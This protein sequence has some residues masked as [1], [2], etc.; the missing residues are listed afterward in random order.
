MSKTKSKGAATDA[1]ILEALSMTIKGA[2][3]IIEID[4]ELLTDSKYQP[5]LDYREESIR[6]LADNIDENGLL[7]M[8]LVHRGVGECREIICG[9]RRVRACALL[10]WRVMPVRLITAD[11]TP[12]E[13]RAIQLS[14]NI[15]REDL[16]P[17]ETAKAYDG[18]LLATGSLRFVADAIGVKTATI[19][20]Q[21]K[22]LTL[23]PEFQAD[24]IAKK[25]TLGA[26]YALAELSVS[27]QGEVWS[28]IQKESENHWRSHVDPGPRITEAL[29]ADI[30][31]GREMELRSA[32]FD[33]N[34]SD[35]FGGA[36]STCP[37]RS[38]VAP[39]LFGISKD[40]VCLD[41]DCFE[42]KTKH[43][44]EKLLEKYGQTEPRKPDARFYSQWADER[45]QGDRLSRLEAASGIRIERAVFQLHNHIGVY[46]SQSSA[47]QAQRIIDKRQA[48]SAAE[49]AAA[50]VA[51]E[52][53]D[54]QSPKA[55][56]DP[57][58][59]LQKDLEA[60]H[61]EDLEE[62]SGL[63]SQDHWDHIEE[64]L[65]AQAAQ[66][67]KAP[68]AG[69]ERYAWLCQRIRISLSAPLLDLDLL[70]LAVMALWPLMPATNGL[71]LGELL[72]DLA[73][74]HEGTRSDRFNLASILLTA[75][76]SESRESPNEELESELLEEMIKRL[77][78][79]KQEGKR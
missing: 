38:S 30:I 48:V 65:D 69:L 11:L 61:R 78:L 50:P 60:A 34:E 36:C 58:A 75:I 14:E 68:K 54:D 49:T 8:P 23:I 42:T 27:D 41:R 47:N 56:E 40:D 70:R 24:L 4:P 59:S 9:H 66:R 2:V 12:T 6:E 15:C 1:E 29:V 16:D 3:E 31:R 57:K 25:M 79:S 45:F 73:L 74:D 64:R 21:L 5:R 17:I 18:L 26:A 52:M 10:G 22:L 19:K 67:E 46:Y 35:C 7:Q 13:I 63:I 33:I 44:I 76:T 28:E 77:R 72:S 20:R 55:S 37:K 53:R 32:P 43:H 71:D 62:K 39:D 51:D